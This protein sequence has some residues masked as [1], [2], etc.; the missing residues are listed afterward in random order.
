MD[1]QEK[2]RKPEKEFWVWFEGIKP[3]RVGPQVLQ[4]LVNKRGSAVKVMNINKSGGWQEASKIGFVPENPIITEPISKEEL[5]NCKDEVSAP[6]MGKTRKYM[7]KEESTSFILKNGILK[8]FR[9]LTESGRVINA[10][11]TIAGKLVKFKKARLLL[12]QET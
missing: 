4:R 10:P 11:V 3:T 2:L 7:N 1:E 5:Q 9:L 6:K 8:Q 12:N